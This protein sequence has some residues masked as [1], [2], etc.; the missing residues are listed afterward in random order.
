MTAYLR[1]GWDLAQDLNIHI[2][3]VHRLTDFGAVV[4]HTRHMGLRRRALTPSGTR[5]TS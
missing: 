2:E 4:S 5:S 3:A 1:A